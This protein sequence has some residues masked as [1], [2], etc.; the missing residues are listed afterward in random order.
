[1]PGQLAAWWRRLPDLGQ[2]LMVGVLVV[3]GWTAATLAVQLPP[4]GDGRTLALPADQNQVAM[5]ATAAVLTLRRMVPP[6][7]LLL[8]VPLYVVVQSLPLYDRLQ[9]G[10]GVLAHATEFHLLPI[11]AVAY[12]VAQSGAISPLV[13]GAVCLAGTGALFGDLD[14]LTLA[15]GFDW[16]RLLF[17]L[18]VVAGTTFL[19][20]LVREQRRLRG[21][22]SQKVVVEER[23]RIARELHDVVAHHV[24]AI[25]IRAQA[26][27]RLAP[28]RPEV[29]VEAVRWIAD[30]GKEALTGMRHAVQVLREADGDR[31][32]Q[33]A[34]QPTMADLRGT[35][36]RLAPGGLD[37]EMALPDPLPAVDPQVEL[38]A[39][40][41]AQ[42]GVTNALRHAEARRA[43]VR[44]A[45]E[46]GHLVVAVDDDGRS[47]KA[48]ALS[49]SGHG[50]RGMAERAAACGGRLDIAR[51]DLG[52][53]SVR[54]TLPC[55]QNGRQ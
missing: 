11:L 20:A 4:V 54:A 40:R 27:E 43:V 10:G 39:V 50:L 37:V 23:T 17:A 15:P 31:A 45:E 41:I 22:E 33:L 14:D 55:H 8:A 36:E 32:V 46:A 42:E 6:A 44:V 5:W 53:W 28:G 3:V 9:L 24:S 48:P 34:P 18:F 16:S 47:G 26:A 13:A 29:A 35:V 12:L 52:G 38:A 51:S 7:A 1:M 19:G 30:A 25:V 49:A 21:V 2:D